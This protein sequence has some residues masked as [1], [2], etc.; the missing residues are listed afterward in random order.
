M[1]NNKS[2][3]P[4]LTLIALLTLS[5]GCAS[6]SIPSAPPSVQPARRPPLPLEG[7]QPPIPSICSPT[8]SAGL[9]REREIWR[10]SLTNAAPPAPPASGIPTLP[11][12]K[13]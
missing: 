9:T 3:L 4:A 5:A 11:N 7:R 6:N 1:A 8:C 10:E 12:L 13:Q 2:P